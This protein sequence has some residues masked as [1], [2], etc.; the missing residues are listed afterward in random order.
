MSKTYPELDLIYPDQESWTIPAILADRAKT[1]AG[2]TFII[3]GEGPE[4]DLTYDETHRLANSV[5][6]G[7]IEDGVEPG[8]RVGILLH[9]CP[10]FL[11]AWFGI[12]GAGAIEVPINV[13]YVG[14]F[15]EHAINLMGPKAMVVSTELAP[16][17]VASRENLSQEMSFF[18]VGSGPE[19]DAAIKQ[20]N[21]AGWAAGPFDA[22]K[23]FTDNSPE[24]EIKR[25]DLGAI[26]STSGTTGPSK[27]VRMPN[28]QLVVSGILIANLGRMTDQDVFQLANPLFHGNAQFMTT[29][30]AMLVGAPVVIF[31]RFSPSRF[32]DR[33]S[34]HGITV[35]NLL[36]AMMDW[37]WRQPRKDEDAEIPLRVV[38]SCPTPASIAPGFQERFG[39]EAI[40]ECF[41]QTEIALPFLTPFGEERP[42]GAVG[43]PV[44]EYFDVR[45]V[46]PDTELDVEVGE[47]GEL[48]VR[49]KLPWT[50]NDGYWGMPD[51]TLNATKNLWFHTGD[52][53]KRDEAGWYYFTDR[54]KDTL[55]RRGEN[56][57]SFEVEEAILQHPAIEECAVIAVPAEFEGGEDEVKAVMVS[58]SPPDMRDLVLWA[59]ERM[60]YFVVPRYWEF[61]DELPKTPSSK[62]RKSVLREV[63]LTDATFDREAAGI[64]VSRA[65]QAA[66]GRDL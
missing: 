6:N 13:D 23:A 8:D 63:G 27:G 38:V 53:L 60:P 5:A 20:L 62:I 47:V 34:K 30:P 2:K 52:G 25:E 32:A 50:I 24:V 31:D 10:D 65:T 15:L 64:E 4:A 3:D 43:V 58:S 9:N 11:L 39:I 48:Y 1:H 61:V 12:A 66:V 19:L 40:V 16:R 37:V 59:R 49:N 28:A 45:L 56:I 57:S 29:I 54:M 26:L 18:V 35:V 42:A 46:D 51:A 33:I 55:R 41:G 14:A 7:L 21:D 22:L 44:D 17:V 36:G